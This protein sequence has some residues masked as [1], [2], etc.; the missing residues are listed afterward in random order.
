MKSFQETDKEYEERVTAFRLMCVEYVNTE[1]DRK[2]FEDW[3]NN[4]YTGDVYYNP[5]D[6]DLVEDR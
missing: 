2:D 5:E 3:Q 1:V 6:D 4:T